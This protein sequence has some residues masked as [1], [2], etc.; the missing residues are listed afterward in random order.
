MIKTFDDFYDAILYI[1]D[2]DPGAYEYY[3]IE[4]FRTE[5]GRWRVGLITERKLELS[6]DNN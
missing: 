2:S 3:K 5:D 1:E 6:L 4:L